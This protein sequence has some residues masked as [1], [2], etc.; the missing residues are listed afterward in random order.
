MLENQP[1]YT[2]LKLRNYPYIYS[3]FNNISAAC[4]FTA[5]VR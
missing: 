3:Y 4:N 2:L 1:V 5:Y